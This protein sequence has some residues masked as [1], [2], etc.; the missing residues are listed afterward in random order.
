M[1]ATLPREL[2][3][4]TNNM[5]VDFETQ[6]KAAFAEYTEGTAKEYTFQDRLRFLD[7]C[8]ESLHGGKDSD[9]TVMEYLKSRM[10]S[11]IRN[12]EFPCE[13]DYYNFD[14]MV[15]MF[16]MGKEYQSMYKQYYDGGRHEKENIEKI[17]TRIIK[18]LFVN[19]EIDVLD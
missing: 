3:I 17:I 2:E 8:I 11:D 5:P 6:V 18:A 1:I 4:D 10:E 15:E 16:E 7:L 9:D 19:E 12:G 14:F 13:S